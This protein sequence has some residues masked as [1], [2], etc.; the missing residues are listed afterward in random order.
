[1]GGENVSVYPDY[2]YNQDKLIFVTIGWEFVRGII[3]TEFCYIQSCNSV[4]TMHSQLKFSLI[5][6]NDNGYIEL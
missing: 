5:C 1:M 6:Y 4:K 2:Q 3:I